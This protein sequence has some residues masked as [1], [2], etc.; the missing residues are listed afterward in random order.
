MRPPVD[1][2]WTAADQKRADLFEQQMR[3]LAAQKRDGH[4]DVMVLAFVQTLGSLMRDRLRASPER[5]AFY[6]HLLERLTQHVAAGI[7][8]PDEA[9]H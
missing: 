4:P 7:A 6:A 8:Q 3:D 9:R 5:W 2:E 1:A